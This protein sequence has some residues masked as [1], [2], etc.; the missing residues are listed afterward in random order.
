MPMITVPVISMTMTR[1][2]MRIMCVASV[3][4]MA[5]AGR[6]VPS[7]STRLMRISRVHVEPNSPTGLSV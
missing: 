1:V 6:T 7:A 3:S 5:M 4:S 2:S